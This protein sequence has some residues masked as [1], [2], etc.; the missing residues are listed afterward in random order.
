ML[1]VN[2]NRTL[3]PKEAAARA[4]ETKSLD[5]FSAWEDVS[6][7][8]AANTLD[9]VLADP[10]DARF[11]DAQK[12]RNVLDAAREATRRGLQRGVLGRGKS[13]TATRELNPAEAR[14][15]VSVGL[16][17]GLIPSYQQSIPTT[18]RS[19]TQTELDQITKD[20]SFENVRRILSRLEV[21]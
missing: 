3:D 16:T 8:A 12:L 21:K 1:Q 7:V 18:V 9:A 13:A 4:I 17:G 10:A 5:N 6:G 2:R 14:S 19:F 20:P 11:A 15:G